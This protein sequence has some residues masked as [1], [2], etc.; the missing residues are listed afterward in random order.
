MGRCRKKG[1]FKRKI[2]IEKGV[3]CLLVNSDRGK[4]VVESSA[5]EQYT[6]SYE[7]IKDGN[8]PLNHPSR[9]TDKRSVILTEWRKRKSWAE[10]NQYWKKHD[11]KLSY[12]IWSSIPVSLQHKIRLLLG[13]R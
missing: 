11:F 2:D 10:V 9:H 3:S 8:E 5:I 12:L 6:V 1:R 13:K 7:D 4:T